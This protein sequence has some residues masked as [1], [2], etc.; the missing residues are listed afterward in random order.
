MIAQATGKAQEELDAV[1]GLLQRLARAFNHEAGGMEAV[2]REIVN[3]GHWLH[4]HPG[5]PAGELVTEWLDEQN[6]R[7]PLDS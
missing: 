1:A 5:E 6:H 3:L 7:T 4:L 2:G